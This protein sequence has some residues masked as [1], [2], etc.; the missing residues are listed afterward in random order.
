MTTF[1]TT[2]TELRKLLDEIAD[3]KIQLPDFQRGWVWDDDHIRSLLVSVA[4]SFPIGAV[5]LLETGGET[6]FQVR[7]VESVNLSPSA[8]PERLI[9][10]GQQRLTSLTQV[11]KTP[12]PVVTR[13][14]KNRQIRRHY[15][16][17]IERAINGDGSL[18]EAIIAVDEKRMIRTNF[19]RDV[20]LDLSSPEKEYES[21]HFPCTQIL[22]SDAWEQGLIARFPHRFTRY[23]E[24]R[25]RIVGAFRSYL[26]ISLRDAGKRTARLWRCARSSVVRDRFARIP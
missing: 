3:G 11:L 24:F 12:E 10:D 9:L 14:E 4:R 5:M 26:V 7:P 20:L 13:D 8:R 23:M 19:N 16:F 2:K 22:N 15:Y 6:R 17:D 25:Q 1:D 18:E 21:F